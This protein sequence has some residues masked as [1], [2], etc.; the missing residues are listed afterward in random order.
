MIILYGIFIVISSGILLQSQHEE[1]LQEGLN[2]VDDNVTKPIVKRQVN[3]EAAPE[4]VPE[5]AP[6]TVPEVAP[7]AVPEVTPEAVSEVTPETVPEVA[8]EAVPAVAPEAT[9][10]SEENPADAPSASL[11]ELIANMVGGLPLVNLVFQ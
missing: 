2:A 7:E 8:P 3:P 1:N 11:S 4:A 5:V 10:T 6:E 9:P